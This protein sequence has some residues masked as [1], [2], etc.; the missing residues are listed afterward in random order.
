MGWLN[1]RKYMVADLNKKTR[2]SCNTFFMNT[3]LVRMYI[4]I[5]ILPPQFLL[6]WQNHIK[7]F[8]N[9]H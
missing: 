8:Q 6:P 1:L 9:F 5:I 7:I 2:I 4:N 3:A